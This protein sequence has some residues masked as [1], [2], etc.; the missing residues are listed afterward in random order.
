M[1][2]SRC[3]VSTLLFQQK[4]YEEVRKVVGYSTDGEPDFSMDDL[5]ELTYLEQCIKE[6]L[7]VFTLFPITLR[8]TCEDITLNGR[9]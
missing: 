3:V 5:A 4:V 9:Q 6:T 1:V 8:K 7:R 2:A